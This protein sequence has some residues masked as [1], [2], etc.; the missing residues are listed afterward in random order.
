MII[1]SIFLPRFKKV[2]FDIYIR[3]HFIV[4]KNFLSFVTFSSEIES[5]EITSPNISSALNLV[6]FII[7]IRLLT[8]CY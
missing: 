5:F 8:K 3:I 2:K 4:A 7:S 1:I 6:D